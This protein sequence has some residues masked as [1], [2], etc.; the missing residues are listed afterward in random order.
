MMPGT[1]RYDT[2][3]RFVQVQSRHEKGKKKKKQESLTKQALERG[4]NV[5]L[6]EEEEVAAEK[7]G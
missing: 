3:Q 1:V 4:C 2:N 7:S 5:E 6:V